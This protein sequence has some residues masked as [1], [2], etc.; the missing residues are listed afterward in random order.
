MDAGGPV[1][2]VD[3]RKKELVGNFRRG[4][5]EWQPAGSPE[6][7]NVHDFTDKELGKAIPCGVYDI[8]ADVG[9]VNVGTDH[10]TAA[11]RCRPSGPGGAR[12]ASRLIPVRGAC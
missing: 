7:V 10:D 11:F 4:G 9:W 2:S 1:I 3:A 5:R 6:R 8:A 12:P